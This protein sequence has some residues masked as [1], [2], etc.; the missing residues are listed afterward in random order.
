[1]MNGWFSQI[2]NILSGSIRLDSEE[3]RC[4]YHCL[5]DQ[6]N[7][8][9]QLFPSPS[10]SLLFPVSLY[11]Y[12]VSRLTLSLCCFPSHS[13]SLLFP[14]SLYLYA[15]SRLPLSLC[16][17]P[18]HSFSMLFPVSLYLSAVSLPPLSLQL[19][20]VSFKKK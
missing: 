13:I 14:V 12:A 10:I 8:I 19:Y 9:F 11:L 18:S 20:C 1:M 4:D 6:R 7:L 16:C 17:F 3:I 15:V 5:E 2:S